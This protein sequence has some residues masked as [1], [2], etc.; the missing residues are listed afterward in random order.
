VVAASPRDI[1]P[2]AVDTGGGRPLRVLVVSAQFPYPPR[3]GFAMR[4]DHLCRRL[5]ARH[6]VTL[7]TYAP[8][9]GTAP[10]DP[11]DP[12]IRVEVVHR[13]RPSLASKRA[14]QARSVVSRRPYICGATHSPEMQQALDA[15]SA[16]TPFDVIQLESSLMGAFRYPAAA[17]LVLDEHN[18]EY[19]V[20]ERLAAGERSRLRRW[21]HRREEAQFR[22]FEQG[23]WRRV[24]GCLVT[25]EREEKIV[26]RVAP[27]TP[28]AVVPNGV[29]LDE[30]RPAQATPQPATAVFN[31]LLHYRPNLDAAF[32]LV[33]EIW[34]LV[35][36]QRPDARLT[37]VGR[38]DD[39]DLR[40]LRRPG[41]EVTGEVP[42]VRPSLDRAAV[43]VVPVRMGGGTRLKVLEGLAMEKPMVST[44]LGCEGVDVRD[45]EHLLVAD[46]PAAFAAAVIRLFADP[47]AARAL[48]RAGRARMDEAYSWDLAGSRLDALYDRIATTEA[49]S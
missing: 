22:R 2:E 33:E 36:T 35:Q 8:L 13:R 46:S 41:V 6:E 3:S 26:L 25:S 47:A 24:D 42:D 48:G 43:V 14:A 28:I 18:V 10:G 23:W 32:F 11:P 45:G 7:L 12:D 17:R 15:L 29:D 49:A 19:E 1:G 31:G 38:G 44:A 20:F 30:F 4:V 21:F 34:P 40:R 9:P 5:A 16:A 39:G 27:A 37:I